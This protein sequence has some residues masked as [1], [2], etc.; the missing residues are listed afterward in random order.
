MNGINKIQIDRYIQ[1]L[2]L[3]DPVKY[4]GKVTQVIGLTIESCGPEVKIGDLCLITPSHSR[5]PIEAEV[6]GFRG[7]KVLLFPL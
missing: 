2:S 1:H 7:N 3:I 4:N 5:E 6:V